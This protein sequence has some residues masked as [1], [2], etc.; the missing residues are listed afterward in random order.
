MLHEFIA[1]HR[2]DI[3]A[4][5]RDRV[6][7][8]PWPVVSS[9]EIEQGVPLFLTQLT[10]TLRL[11]STERPFAS[12]AIASTAMRHRAELAAAGFTVAQVVH[13]Y[14]GICQAITEIAVEQHAPMTVEECHTLNRCLDTA[15]AEAVTEHSRLVSDQRS[16][17]KSSATVRWR[18]SCATSSMAPSSRFTRS[19]EAQ[20]RSTAVPGWCWGAA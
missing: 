16:R 5:T 2:E 11:E 14:G 20:S 12:G 4:R 9:R 7:S 13:D 19:S 1:I 3:V 8:R 10:E 18:T 6:R 15:I 17:R